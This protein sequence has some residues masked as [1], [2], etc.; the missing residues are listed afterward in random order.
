[1]T[2]EKEPEQTAAEKPP[3]VE[4]DKPPPDEFFGRGNKK[5]KPGKQ[6]PVKS[7]VE[8]QI[9]AALAQ[10]SLQA[11]RA[12]QKKQQFKYGLIAAGVLLVSYVIYWGFKPYQGSMAF[13]I[14]K[15]FLEG[16]VRFPSLLRVSTVEEFDTF[17]RIWYTQVDSFGEYR[18][19]SIQ[20]YYKQDPERGT[21]V[22]KVL[23]N[24]REVDPRKVEDFNRSLSVI[25]AHPPDLTIPPPLPDSLQNLQLDT[26]SFRKPVF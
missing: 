11:K 18:M 12:K 20:C 13:G 9:D 5:K 22:D 26:N 4:P 25:L 16:Q 14:C 21:V 8:E 2:S 23:I 24:R 3:G 15:V 10:S 17:V 19:E 1:M 7:Q 6:K